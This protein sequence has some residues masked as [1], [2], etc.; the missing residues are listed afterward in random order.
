MEKL[1]LNRVAIVIPYF[2][3]LPQ[4]VDLWLESTKRNPKIDFLI[5]TDIEEVRNHSYLDNVKIHHISFN[6]FK[7][8][9]QKNFEFDL[10]LE[11]PYKLC[12]YRP[13]YGLVLSS[14]LKD[15]DYWGF[16]DMDLIWGDIY[17]FI[18]PL[19]SK[20]YD[21]IFDLGHLSLIKNTPKM[22]HLFLQKNNYKDCLSY[23]YVFTN[24]FSFFYDETGSLRY[25]FGQAEVC[26]RLSN[27]SI[28][29]KRICANVSPDKYNFYL[30]DLNKEIEYF[31][32]KEGHILG[33]GIEGKTEYPYVHLSRRL[34][35]IDSN[36]DLDHFYIGPQIISSNLGKIKILNKSR[37]SKFIF[38]CQTI[39]RHIRQ[40][41]KK[42]SDGA[43]K[44][45]LNVRKNK[46]NI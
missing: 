36:L 29:S 12:D 40:K 39:G 41:K 42:I 3:K 5:F 35:K 23:K 11:K 26:R 14:Y 4:L 32:F 44:Y 38:K 2:G 34:F 45:Y 9:F 15:Y 6:E 28:Y 46:I 13:S 22:N 16:G 18:E 24:D 10:S 7:Q 17:K 1:N 21:R 20:E 19:L 37:K 30:L 33:K 43:F 31:E 27:I 25:G 8:K